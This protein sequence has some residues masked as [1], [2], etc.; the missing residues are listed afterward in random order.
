M[1]VIT[2]YL[3]EQGINI[4]NNIKPKSNIKIEVKTEQFKEVILN[5]RF[6]QIID[7]KGRKKIVSY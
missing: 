2:A 3:I 7:E 1:N 6:K 4:S 5:E